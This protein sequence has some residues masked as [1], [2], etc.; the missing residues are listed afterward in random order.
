MSDKP[1]NG[2]PAK[3]A[4]PELE[5]IGPNTIMQSVQPHQNGE[6]KDYFAEMVHGGLYISAGYGIPDF[7][8][9]QVQGAMDVADATWQKLRT[10]ITAAAQEGRGIPAIKVIAD[11]R[12]HIQH[13][14]TTMQQ[15]EQ[16]AAEMA[17]ALEVMGQRALLAQ[18]EF[19]TL[20]KALDNYANGANWPREIVSGGLELVTRELQA[21]KDSQSDVVDAEFEEVEPL[22]P[23][24]MPEPVV[25]E[26]PLETEAVEESQPKA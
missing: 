3:P 26:A 7:L 6:G 2:Q 10:Q 22:T 4:Q 12:M 23:P 17:H 9:D 5:Q 21:I 16:K 15:L 13:L 20:W 8:A 11:Q 1:L 18:S 14:T 24:A 19:D 25:D